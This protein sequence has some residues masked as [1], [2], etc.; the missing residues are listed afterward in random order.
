MVEAEPDAPAMMIESYG[1]QQGG[2]EEGCENELIIKA[3]YDKTK[4]VNNQNHHLRR[5]HI[6]QD[7]PDEETFLT[8]KERVACRTMMLDFEWTLN[9]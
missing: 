4:K 2:D 3:E 5:N 6:N 7:C 1:K 8:H 9:D